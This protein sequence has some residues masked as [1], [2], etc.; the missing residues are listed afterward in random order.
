[1]EEKKAI[2]SPF[3][4]GKRIKVVPIIKTGWL[5]RTDHA[6][7]VMFDQTSIN[8]TVPYDKHTGHLKQVLTKEEKEFFESGDFDFNKGELDHRRGE[9]KG[10]EDNY[11]KNFSVRLEKPADG[12]IKEGQPLLV[13]DLSEDYHQYFQYKVLLA[14]TSTSG[15]VAPSWEE[16]RSSA[17]YK[18]A[19]VDKDEVETEVVTKYF[20]EKKINAF[21]AKID[22]SPV[23][24][25]EFLYICHLEDPVLLEP[26]NAADIEWYIRQVEKLKQSKPELLLKIIKNEDD[27]PYRVLIHKGIRAKALNYSK[28]TGITNSEGKVFGYTVDT[29]IEYLKDSRFQ[30][31]MMKLEFRVEEFSKKKK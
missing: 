1:M 26:D 3:K 7:S 8:I 11:W 21:L 23:K 14:N 17:S 15:I 18:V 13:L 6:A 25:Y 24:L 31:D 5:G 20:N 16:R 4:K 10:L 28:S 19:L 9:R 30:E 12:I 29:A 27:Y 22:T 2:K